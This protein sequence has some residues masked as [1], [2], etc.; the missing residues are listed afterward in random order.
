MWF[1]Y[2]PTYSVEANSFKL[3]YWKTDSPCSVCV[4]DFKLSGAP[5]VPASPDPPLFA[6]PTRD[7][8]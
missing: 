2:I 1:E 8:H 7:N 3:D 6:E 4:N 5:P